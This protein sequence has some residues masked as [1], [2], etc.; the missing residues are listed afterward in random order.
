MRKI[1]LGLS[2]VAAVIIGAAIAF[3][4]TYLPPTSPVNQNDYVQIVK[5]GQGSAQST[6][7]WAGTV[8][9][10]VQ[11]QYSVPSTGFAI[12]VTNGNTFVL[13][14][15]SG[16]LATGAVT[17]PSLPGDGQRLCIMSSQTQTAITPTAVTGQG[18]ATYGGAAVTA[19][20]ANTPV[21]WFY[22][23]N[24]ALWVRYL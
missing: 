7:A 9:G 21:C 24:Q 22:I 14:N 2:A 8:A 1:F 4:Q 19:L 5:G 10:T 16:T 11:Y 18:F 13:I 23:L 20:T 3:S 12:T 6:Y 17:F 15:P